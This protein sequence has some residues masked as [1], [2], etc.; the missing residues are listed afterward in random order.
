M[1]GH[2][3]P[4]RFLIRLS[5]FKNIIG[6]YFYIKFPALRFLSRLFGFSNHTQRIRPL[7]YVFCPGSLG[8]KTA[9]QHSF[10]LT[11]LHYVFD[12]AFLVLEITCNVAA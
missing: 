11:R 8:F 5:G 10:S 12:P 1:S 9:L 4:L 7:H 2:S 6:F 3:S